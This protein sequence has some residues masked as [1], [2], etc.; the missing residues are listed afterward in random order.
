MKMAIFAAAFALSGAAL[1]QDMQPAPA[2]TPPET[3][4]PETP[5]PPAPTSVPAD[6]SAPQLDNQGTPVISSPAEAPAGFNQPPQVGGTGA[7]P[8]ARPAPQPATQNYPRC[9]RTVTDNCVQREGRSP[10]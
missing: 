7:A 9:S 8:D 4:M 5:P 10:R 2:P 3:A 6:N 1:A